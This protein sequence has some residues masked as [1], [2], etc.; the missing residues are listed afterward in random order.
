[1]SASPKPEIPSGNEASA[2]SSPARRTTLPR[3]TDATAVASSSGTTATTSRADASVPGTQQGDDADASGAATPESDSAKRSCATG[4]VDD[5][6]QLGTCTSPEASARVAV[7]GDGDLLS[8]AVHLAL[9]TQG[10]EAFFVE[11]RDQPP[12]AAVQAVGPP[13]GVLAIVLASPDKTA[14]AVQRMRSLSA[15]GVPVVAVNSIPHP[16]ATSACHAAGAAEVLCASDTL[17]RLMTA[18]AA[19][20]PQTSA[21]GPRAIP[22]LA[23]ARA[24]PLRPAYPVARRPHG[25]HRFQAVEEARARIARLTEREQ[26]L[27][28]HMIR[29]VATKSIARLLGIALSTA[30]THVAAILR[31]LE[32]TSQIQAV[33]VARTADWP[34]DAS[35]AGGTDSSAP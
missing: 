16:I 13:A 29:G 27:F 5:V 6:A 26:E 33:A 31:K 15:A 9:V 10:L 25:D 12:G 11:T 4:N 32:V 19:L 1:M 8:E 28:V 30:R 23:P 34:S 17:E 35:P 22:V 18:I 7:F 3:R 14:E 2:T 24:D 20:Q 21:P